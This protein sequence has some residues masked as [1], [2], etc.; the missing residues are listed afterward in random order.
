MALVGFAGCNREP[1]QSLEYAEQQYERHLT[2]LK[3]HTVGAAKKSNIAHSK[4]LAFEARYR[5]LPAER[6][7]RTTRLVML[8]SKMSSAVSDLRRLDQRPKKKPAKKKKKKKKKKK[9]P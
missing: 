8:N 5:Q 9:T 2:S 1:T 7:A 6:R 4:I 3:R